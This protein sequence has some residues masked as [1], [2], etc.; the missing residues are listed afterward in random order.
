M[1]RETIRIDIVLK[2]MLITMTLIAATVNVYTMSPLV[3]A[4]Q[5]YHI[6]ILGTGYVPKTLFITVG[7][8]VTWT[9][10][11]TGNHTVT[12][13]TGLNDPERASKFDSLDL[14]AKASFSFIF[15]MPGIYHYFDK[16]SNMQGV[17]TVT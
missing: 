16:K 3:S 8:T 12:S 1:N 10:N 17:I 2:T 6:S 9:N 5:A 11:D 4:Q 13:G 7:S 14:G 15:N